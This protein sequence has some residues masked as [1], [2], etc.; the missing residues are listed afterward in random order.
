MPVRSRELVEAELFGAEPGAF[1]GATKLR[2]GRFEEADGGTIF[3]D[4]IGNLPLEGQKK[5]LRVLQTGEYQRLGSS[6]ARRTNVRVISATNADVLLAIAEGR[7][8]E[9]LYFRLNVIEL[10][11]PA[12]RDR[13]EDVEPLAELFLARENEKAK[14]ALALD[15]AAR[16]LLVEHDWPGNVRELENRIVRATL[17]A[18]GDT[19][20]AADLGLPGEKR[21]ETP[22]AA[23]SSERAEI[24]KTLLDARGV[25]STAAARLGLSR[26][27]LYRRMDRLGIQLDRKPR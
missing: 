24:E 15:D 18:A 23:S 6:V 1:T 27:A 4:E 14:S 21:T 25:V 5:L 8:R 26:Q 11:M 16:R 3:L 7:F 13:I 10:A 20:S 22:R 17:V 12:L 19:I 9:D 2:V